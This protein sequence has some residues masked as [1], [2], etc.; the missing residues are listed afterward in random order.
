MASHIR[1][2]IKLLEL[3]DLTKRNIGKWLLNLHAV[4]SENFEWCNLNISKLVWVSS[5]F[6]KICW[7]T[8]LTIFKIFSKIPYNFFRRNHILII[9][10]INASDQNSCVPFLTNEFFGIFED[11]FT[12]T[13]KDS[14]NSSDS[15]GVYFFRFPSSL[16]FW[17][18]I[19]WC[20]W[21][22]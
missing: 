9:K 10:T 1:K 19:F 20:Y 4:A 3:F 18:Y 11:L 5:L 12:K 13:L 22:K 21:S 17:M 15:V 6:A 8:L 2:E 14:R 16:Q 7:R